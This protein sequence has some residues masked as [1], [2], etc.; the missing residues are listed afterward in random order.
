MNLMFLGPPGAGKGT[1]AVRLAEKFNIPH[2][3]TG[4]MLRQEIK[5]GTELGEKAKAYISEGKLVPDDVIIG[6]I[7]GRIAK[8]DA[9]EGFI[10]DGFPRTREQAQ[11]LE[12][13]TK[14]DAVVNIDSRDD[15]IVKRICGRRVCDECGAIYQE[16]KL[17]NKASCLKCGGRL[18][19]REDDNEETIRKRLCEYKK[20]T[21][22]LIGFYAERGILHNIPDNGTI[23]D[24]T[25]NIL[26]VL[27]TVYDSI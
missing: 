4:D 10:L 16:S 14:L 2:I 7:E 19:V 12:G 6:M 21:M 13:F 25:Q 26:A 8:P 22:P 17:T 18:C 1:Q 20:K 27:C 24:I 11:A 23:D 15:Q 3:S 5:N 9:R